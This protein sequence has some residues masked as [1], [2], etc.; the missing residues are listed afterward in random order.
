VADVGW[1][2]KNPISVRLAGE[3]AAEVT[4]RL[5]EG[6][7]PAGVIRRDLSRYYAACRSALKRL[8]FDYSE[9]EILVAILGLTTVDG[10]STRYLWAEIDELVRAKPAQFPEGSQKKQRADGLVEQLRKCSP[11]D[12]LAILDAVE[13]YWNAFRQSRAA[14]EDQLTA[15][16]KGFENSGLTQDLPWAEE[17]ES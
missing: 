12:A 14:G 8:R 3:L 10:A 9:A 16:L 4:Y 1:A 6:R 17:N 13:I 2:T 7:S 5:D 11:L 15:E